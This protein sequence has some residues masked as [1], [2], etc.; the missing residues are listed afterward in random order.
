MHEHL[1]ASFNHQFVVAVHNTQGHYKHAMH[2]FHHSLTYC[3]HLRGGFIE[4][5]Y[6]V[7]LHVLVSTQDAS[8]LTTSEFYQYAHNLL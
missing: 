5:L 4:A 1:Y 6:V 7:L 3:H 2:V 8:A